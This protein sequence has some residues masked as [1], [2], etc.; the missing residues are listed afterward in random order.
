MVPGTE[1]GGGASQDVGTVDTI[2][3]SEVVVM[4]LE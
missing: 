3:V 1:Q 4:R 2:K